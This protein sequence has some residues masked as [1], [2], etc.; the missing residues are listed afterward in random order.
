VIEAC[1]DTSSIAIEATLVAFS[2]AQTL[3]AAELRQRAVALAA[4]LWPGHPEDR[5]GAAELLAGLADW[6]PAL[7]RRA[8]LDETG[9]ASAGSDLLA[10]AIECAEDETR[11]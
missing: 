5:R 6:D 10:D 1:A 3:D 9:L 8:M 11:G 7:L 2:Y 4:D